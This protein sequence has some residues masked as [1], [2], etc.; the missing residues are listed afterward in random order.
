MSQSSSSR[1]LSVQT[2]INIALLAVFFVVMATSLMFTVMSERK[3]VL[4]VVEQQTRDAADSYFDSINTMM[5]TGTMAQRNVLRDKILAP[6]C[7]R[8]AHHP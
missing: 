7:G 6:R 2:K 4:D 8:G 3:L 1:Q 5:L